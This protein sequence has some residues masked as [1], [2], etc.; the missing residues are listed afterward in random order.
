[1]EDRDN[2]F[3]QFKN[4]AHNVA[5]KEFPSMDNV[6]SRVEEKLD[7]KV[8]K[9]ETK[10][11]RKIAVAASILLFVSVGY[12]FFRSK[13]EIVIPENQVVA[14]DENNDVI[15][16]DTNAKKTEKYPNITQEAKQNLEKNIQISIGLTYNDTS[17][18]ADSSPSPVVI[19]PEM[20]EASA[21]IKSESEKEISDEYLNQEET[22]GILKTKIYDA[23]SVKY[24][25]EVFAK[26]EAQKSVL[27]KKNSLIV[28]DGEAVVDNKNVAEKAKL[29]SIDIDNIEILKQPLY[30]ING[31][32]Y[33][34]EE[35]FG[36]KPTS[37]YAPLEKQDIIKTKV[38]QVEEA[39]E[40]YGEKGKKGVVVITT[41]FGKPFKK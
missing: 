18:N 27:R 37:P 33:S 14:I 36:E 32:Q 26:N 4:A 23:R 1:M 40:L 12:Q 10:I 38:Y 7:A 22:N 13:N 29:N 20:I 41:K 35:L 31:V 28:I 9:N 19:A 21:P 17:I 16:N 34:E 25:E 6:W 30:I 11:W 39:E 3:E 2:I 24:S 8:L 15:E 5:P